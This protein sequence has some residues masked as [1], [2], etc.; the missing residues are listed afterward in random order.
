VTTSSPA[1]VPG[2][3]A[4]AVG[5]SR[6]GAEQPIDLLAVVAVS[7]ALSA[8]TAAEPLCTAAAEHLRAL[9]GAVQVQVVLATEEP[10]W[11]VQPD[12][13]RVTV[14]T[15]VD[16]PR[17]AH[18]APLSAFWQAARTGEPLLV[19]D[20]LDD[21]WFAGDPCL[22]ADAS[23]SLLAVPV[24]DDT[25]ARAVL[26]L[27][28]GSG[29]RPFGPEA[30][31]AVVLVGRQLAVS[32][33]NA[34]RYRSL[35]AR[36]DRIEQMNADGLLAEVP[37]RHRFDEAWAAEWELGRINSRSIALLRIDIDR[38]DDYAATM[39]QP[40]GSQCIQAVAE[41][42]C[43]TVRHSDVVCW[44]GGQEFAIILPRAELRQAFRVAQRAHAAVRA[45]D[46]PHPGEIGRVTVSIGVAA[47]VPDDEHDRQHLLAAADAAL[48]EAKQ[49]GHDQVVAMSPGP[50]DGTPTP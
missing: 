44:Y 45:L 11:I 12:G 30:R 28:S 22:S 39:G 32:L 26:L 21:D 19:P 48:L 36:L 1:V 16:D 42:L 3:R 17:C 40:A 23:C 5:S 18:L 47:H 24:L 25:R 15:P 35:E 8:L 33:D 14:A 7:Q 4:A 2:P 10:G 29:A 37:G 27:R 49:A 43:D 9:T 20:T 6:G 50:L 34:A 31:D 13:D 46:L 38:F 41:A